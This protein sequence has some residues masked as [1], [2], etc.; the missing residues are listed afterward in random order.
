MSKKQTSQKQE[1]STVPKEII[2]IEVPW[3]DLNNYKKYSIKFRFGISILVFLVGFLLYSNTINHGYVLDDSGVIKDNVNV[4]KGIKGIPDILKMDLWEL[5]DVKL[6]YYR[7]LSLITFAIEKEY[8]GNA[9]HVSHFNNVLLFAFSGM[10]LFW[11]LQLL[12]GKYNRWIPLLA[13]FLFLAHPIH[14]EV[15]ANIKSR[16]EILSFL[17]LFLVLFFVLKHIQTR[18]WLWLIPTFVFAYLGM[19][20]KE[21]ALTGLLLVPILFY[22]FNKSSIPQSILKSI[23]IALAI[24][25][26]FVQKKMALG[27]LSAVIPNDI[28]NYPYTTPHVEGS[29]KIATAFYL[30]AHGII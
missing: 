20:S 24:F 22:I 23:P 19:L 8:F 3:Y 25:F 29:F 16:D 12:F 15:V 13:T 5:S 21:T 28:V 4:Q 7:P 17:N 1:K 9:P 10:V 26:F 14:T 18:N 30:F 2:S 27:T 11:V 6:G